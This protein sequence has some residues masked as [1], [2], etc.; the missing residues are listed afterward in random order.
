MRGE[1]SGGEKASGP[2]SIGISDALF[3]C[4]PLSGGSVGV[5]EKRN[6]SDEFSVVFGSAWYIY[7]VEL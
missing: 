3:P 7:N 2:I 6:L 5:V 1:S 4:I